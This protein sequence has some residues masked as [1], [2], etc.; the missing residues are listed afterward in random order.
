[1]LGSI[2]AFMIGAIH[3]LHRLFVSLLARYSWV[4]GRSSVS[5]WPKSVRPWRKME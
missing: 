5:K 4:R 2:F 1:V 3:S